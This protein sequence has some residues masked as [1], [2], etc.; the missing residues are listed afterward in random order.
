METSLL[1]KSEPI[2]DYGSLQSVDAEAGVLGAILLESS[3]AT[4]LFQK[5]NKNLFV[6]GRHRKIYKTMQSLLIENVP[7]D[8][9][10]IIQKLTRQGE[11]AEQEAGGRSYILT[12]QDNCPSTA[13]FSYFLEELQDFAIRRS[14]Y[15]QMQE[16]TKLIGDKTRS[17]A[18]VLEE[19]HKITAKSLRQ[20]VTTRPPIRF[21]S[22]M[23]AREY[24]P[25]EG[26]LLVGDNHITR[27]GIAV[28]GGPPGIGKS[29]AVTALAL[30]GATQRNWLGLQVHTQFKTLIIQAENAELRLAADYS[31]LPAELMEEF[32]RISLPPATGLAFHKEGFKAAV[33]EA[34]EEFAPDIMVIDPWNRAVLDD[35]Q[36]DYQ[37]TL[38][39]I[40]ECLPGEQP[41]ALVIVAHTRKPKDAVKKTGREVLH[42]LSGSNYLGTAPRSV[43]VMTAAANDPEDDRII[44]QNPKNNDGKMSGISAWHRRGGLF[45]ACEGFDWDE[46]HKEP[47]NSK[48]I[49]VKDLEALFESG[50]RLLERKKAVEELMEQTGLGKTAC[51][52]ALKLDGKF[53]QHLSKQGDCLCWLRAGLEQIPDSVSAVA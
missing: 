14:L 4:K 34:C 10:T 3:T 24:V 5:L 28:I 8:E 1:S 42:E 40:Q 46:Y 29:R 26:V 38:Q 2:F 12:L 25:E 49:T 50:D 31:D 13:N 51:Y 36:R 53:A 18:D 48:K 19:F 23:D 33:I 30:S 17:A 9:A 21:I 15:S 16:T 39:N 37:E 7:I 6:D 41:P 52:E 22:P 27:G 32:V 43:F 45:D 35:A 47:E 44:W 20:A 11:D